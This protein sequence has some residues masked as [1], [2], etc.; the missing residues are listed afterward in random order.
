MV[1]FLYDLEVADRH[2]LHLTRSA[3]QQCTEGDIARKPKHP[4]LY[5]RSSRNSLSKVHGFRKVHPTIHRTW[6]PFELNGWSCVC[7]ALTGDC[8]EVTSGTIQLVEALN[9]NAIPIQCNPILTLEHLLLCS[10]SSSYQRMPEFW[11]FCF[12][13]SSLPP[14]VVHSDWISSSSYHYSVLLLFSC[15]FLCACTYSFFILLIL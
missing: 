2:G 15:P 6:L 9:T 1:C 12:A 8:Q 11:W 3:W 10:E 7:C 13:L 4:R 14:I 5:S